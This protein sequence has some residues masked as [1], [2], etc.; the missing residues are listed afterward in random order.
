MRDLSF[1]GKLWS[2]WLPYNSKGNPNI[3][4]G[5]GAIA[6]SMLSLFLTQKGEIA[7]EYN[8]GLAPDIFDPMSDYT[9]EYWIFN[10]EQE[11]AT[12]IPGIAQLRISISGYEAS[13]NRLDT[14][15]SFVPK[16]QPDRNLLVFPFYQYQGAIWDGEIQQFLDGVYL[17]EFPF[18]SLT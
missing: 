18:K 14:F 9:P 7:E 12:W 2:P 15:I 8:F 3:V 1:L 5:T 16:G 6:A 13:D 17:N 10:A 4:S 11:I